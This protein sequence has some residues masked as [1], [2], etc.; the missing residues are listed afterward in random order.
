MIE[1]MR[2]RPNSG[3]IRVWIVIAAGIGAA[4][5]AV[6]IA[7][8][9]HYINKP[10]ALRGAVIQQDDDTLRQSPITDVEI[11]APD[12]LASKATK[13]DFS[14]YFKLTLRPG[15]KRGQTVTVQFRHPDYEPVEMKEVVSDKLLVVRMVPLHPETEEPPEHS[16]IFVSDIFVRYSTEMTAAVNIGTGVKTFQVTNTGNV[17]CDRR[18]ICSPDNKWKAGVGGAVL[19]AGQGNVYQNARVSCIAGPCP[20]T[21][22]ENDG[23]SNGGRNISVTVRGWSDTTTFLFQAEVFRQEIS[24]IVRDSYPVIFGRA[25]NFSLPATARGPSLEAEIGG[26][27]IVFPLA[28]SPT[29]S[30]AVCNVKAGKDG[31][32]SYRC[33]LK[34]GYRFR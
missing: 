24:D 30:W 17:P 11:D 23:F 12:A 1:E 31:S 21:K 10:L 2:S 29:L 8:A 14:G 6:L 20:F 28:P 27:N 25:L 34:Q 13:S 7:V 4:L 19:D 18:S 26:E 3:K 33:E 9:T 15:V 5:A 32:K 16:Q 22:I